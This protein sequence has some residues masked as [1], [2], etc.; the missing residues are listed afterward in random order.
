MV[1]R[2][3]RGFT[4][5]ELMVVLAIL[6]VLLAAAVPSLTAYLHLAQFRRNES[7]AKSIYLSAESTLTYYRGSGQW[8]SFARQL[9]AKGVQVGK[10]DTQLKPELHDR[11][12]A[13]RLDAK[14][15]GSGDGLSDDGA[16]TAQLLAN[17]TYDKS[18]LNGA[19]CLEIDLESG[20][21]YSA[22]YGAPCDGLRYDDEPDR[23][24]GWLNLSDRA[25]DSRKAARLGYY[26]ADDMTN[27]V[28][29]ELTKLKITSISLVNSETLSLS[30]SSN[31]KNHDHDVVYQ[32][33]FFRAGDNT[34]LLSTKLERPPGPAP[35]QITLKVDNQ[36]SKED[37]YTFPLSY[38]D[39]RFTL[40]LDAMMTAELAGNV[41][42]TP[43]APKTK[44]YFGTSITRF[45]GAF[46]TP[47]DIYA[48]VRVL[49]ASGSIDTEYTASNEAKS[50]TANT[51]FTDGSTAAECGIAAFRHL[52]NIRYQNGTGNQ[53]FRITARTLDWTS[54]SVTVYQSVTQQDGSG[55]VMGTRLTR[56]DD[57]AF[58]TVPE[59]GESKT[60]NGSGGGLLSR[61]LTA[62]TGSSAVVR[63]RLDETSVAPAAPGG[64]VYLGLFGQNSGTIT[65]LRLT[66]PEVTYT[67][68]PGQRSVHA[69]GAVCGYD[70]GSLQ[71][72]TVDGKAVV[73]VDL[74]QAERRSIG[75]L[76]GL[77]KP[78]DGR[79]L[80]GL[81]MAGTVNGTVVQ[82]GAAAASMAG[83][84]GIVGY[85]SL[86]P[87]RQLCQL[88]NSE[89]LA[90]VTGDFRVG[91]VAGC[92]LDNA[93]S[94]GAAPS[95]VSLKNC[96]N[97][98]LV[99]GANRD[100]DYVGGIAGYTG[101]AVLEGCTSCS[102]RSTGFAYTADQTNLLQGRYVGGIVG[103]G[104]NSYIRDCATQ[105]DG[106]IL[107]GSY[108]GGIAGGLAG[109]TQQSIQNQNV[110]V[111]AN[112]SYVIG[113][114]Y[115]G[116]IVG[117]NTGNSSIENCVN[118]GV[119]AGYGKYIG[120]ICGT[121]IRRGSDD[122]GVP[123]VKNCA[124]YVSDTDDSIYQKVLKWKAVGSCAGGLVGFNSGKIIFNDEGNNITT[125]S[126]SGIVVGKDYVGG[127]VGFNAEKGNI[128]V[129]YTL[130]GGRV[131]ASGDCVGGLIGLNA[132]EQVLTEALTIQPGSV[133]GRY[134]V[135]GAIGA[136]VVELNGD[137]TMARM[138][139]KNQ[140]GTV[141]GQ[142][143]T[144][145]LIGYHRTYAD[146]QLGG[147][148][149]E[150][151][152]D[153]NKNQLL[154]AIEPG[155]NI[156]KTVLKTTNSHVL[157][158][159]QEGGTA[160]INSMGLRG[161][162]Y[163]GGVVGGCEDG[164]KLVLKNCVNTGGFAMPTVFE[165]SGLA[166]GVD[167][168][169]LLGAEGYPDAA[170][171]LEAELKLNGT[172]L[173]ARIVGGVIGMTGRN[174]VVD[175]CS[176]T[177][178]MN[179]LSVLGG[180]VGLNEG[181][182]VNC[183]LSNNLGGATQ[184]Y[185][186]G[187][188][189]LNV[190][191]KDE[192]VTV[193]GYTY[194]GTSYIPGTV[195]HCATQANRTV[196]G[197]DVVGGIVGCNLDGGRMEQNTSNASVT[198]RTAV[199]GVVGENQGALTL[200]GSAGSEERRVTGQS[201]GSAVGGVIGRNTAGG[202]LAVSGS[203]DVAVTDGKLTVSG[204]DAVGGVI[205]LNRGTIKMPDDA[206]LTNQAKEVRAVN[207]SVGG[208]I[209]EQ[210]GAATLSRAK[211]LGDR[212][213]A[214]AGSAGGIVGVNRSGNTVK[215]CVNQGS[216]T[217]NQG[218]AGGIVSENYGTVT[219]CSVAALSGTITIGSRGADASGAICAVNHS[220][221]TVTGSAPGDGVQFTG[222][223]S[224]LGAVVGDNYGTVGNTTVEKLPEYSRVTPSS[225]T[226]GGAVGRNSTKNS[227]SGT[228]KD[229]T[230]R[231]RFEH[232][233]KYRYLGGVV[234]ENCEDAQVKG[235]SYT[236]TITEGRSAAG[237]CYGGV[238][239][240]NEGV[241]D[242]CTVSQLTIT[243]TGAYT[244]ASNSTAAQKEARSSHIGGIAGKNETTGKIVR[245]TLTAGADKPG[246]ITAKY[247]M[248]GGV[249]GYNKGSISLSGDGDTMKVMEYTKADGT[250]GPV[251]KISQ[252]LKKTGGLSADKTY[253]SY[254]NSVGDLEKAKYSNGT[255][256]IA[257]RTMRVKVIGNGNLGG[258][259][260]Y[261]APTGQLDHCVSGNWFLE[262][263]SG[264]LGVGT[265]GIIGM[266]ESE[267]DLTFLVNRAFVGRYL[268]SA[269]TNRFA[270]GIIGNQVNSTTENWTIRGC[271]NYGTVYCYNSH[272]SGGI[273]GQWTGNGGTI[274]DCYNY[275]NLQTTY[276]TNWV[277]ASGGIV[278]Q[279]YHAASNQSFNI[280]SCQNHG[281]IY[282]A[283]GTGGS[284]A[285]DSAGILGNIT[286]YQASD[287]GQRFT[288]HVVDCVNGPK[289]K[290][291]SASMASGI[292]GF[293][294][295]DGPNKG[296]ISNSTRNVVINLDRCRN[297]SAELR[298]GQW[299]YRAGIFGDRYDSRAAANTY[300]QN[301]YSV[302]VGYNGQ[303]MVSLRGTSSMRLDSSTVGNNYYF[304]AQWNLGQVGSDRKN[305]SGNLSQT[306]Q[307]AWKELVRAGVRQ[308]HFGQDAKGD[309]LAMLVGPDG[310]F[311]E[312]INDF[313]E[314]QTRMYRGATTENSYLDSQG[315]VH[316]YDNGTPVIAARTLFR[317]PEEYRKYM[318]AGNNS[319]GLTN[320]IKQDSAFD[321]YVRSGYHLLER[322]IS[323]G[324]AP[325]KPAKLAKPSGDVTKPGDAVTAVL[326]QDGSVQVS[327]ADNSRPLYYEGELWMNGTAAASGLRFIPNQ[328]DQGEWDGSGYRS[329]TTTSSFQLPESLRDKVNSGSGV[330]LRVRAVSLEENVAPSE[331]TEC[332]VVDTAFLP[333]PNVRVQLVRSGTSYVYQ[334]SLDNLS[335]YA[336]FPNWKVTLTM[337][338]QSIGTLTAAKPTV[339]FAG[340]GVQEL[341]A[342]ATADPI[343][344]KM[345]APA[346]LRVSAYTPVKFLPDSGLN[347]LGFEVTGDTLEDLVITAKLVPAAAAIN[348]PPIFRVELVGTVNGKETVFAYEDVLLAAGAEVDAHFRDM[349]EDIF[350]EATNLGIRAWYAAAGLGP[351]YT[352]APVQ[353]ADQAN[354]TLRNYDK[355][356]SYS[357]SYLN[358]TVLAANQSSPFTRQ[359]N[360]TNRELSQYTA[361]PKPVLGDITSEMKDGSLFY[362]FQWDQ[363][364]NA[365]ANARYRVKLIGE[366]AG[367]QVT[368][369]TDYDE[370]AGART[371]TV[372]A[373]DWSYTNVTLTVT[374]VGD[375]TAKQIGLSA[376]RKY[377]VQ[378]RL[379]R[380]GQPTVENV[381]TNELNY[382]VSWPAISNETG[383]TGYAIHLQY[384]GDDGN[385]VDT[386]LATVPADGSAAYSCVCDLEPYSGKEVLIYLVALADAN[387]KDS[388][389]GVS[390]TLV[391]PERIG[392]PTVTWSTNWTYD[393]ANPVSAGDFRGGGLSVTVIPQ[394]AASTPP[395]GSTYLL[396]AKV[397]DSADGSGTPVA[398]YPASGVLAMS[399]NSGG[400]YV[401]WLNDLSV[402]YAGKYIRFQARISS[403][404][405]QVSS[406]WVTS[407]VYRLPAMRLD[408]PGPITGSQ[409]V[410]T[411][412]SVR[413]N[414][415]L[416]AS[417]AVWT[418]Q[419]TTV[420]WTVTE[421]AEVYELTLNPG[422]AALR[423]GMEKDAVLVQRKKGDIW[424]DL[425]PDDN[426][427]Y[428]VLSGETVY[429]TYVDANG[430]G[431]TYSYVPETTLR[432]EE[433]ED[434]R[435]TF[436]LYL[437]NISAMTGGTDVQ[438]ITLPEQQKQVESLDI[439]AN[440]WD[441]LTDIPSD[442]YVASEK[443]ELKF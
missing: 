96:A 315:A 177:G 380:P 434:G 273:L 284:G 392:V 325:A 84:G 426:D 361:L 307:S 260:G 354:V 393:R 90:N 65:G 231:A 107:G 179:G 353:S 336:A 264:S 372:N 349:P 3:R 135:G 377:P 36:G 77:A 188:A 245:C 335:S 83:I 389:N 317:L 66:A 432:G 198:G 162:A 59:L 78:A 351:V 9:K 11:L 136:N 323:D 383:C 104:K 235:S 442:A 286:T 278:A 322:T 127:L 156:P 360:N 319:T 169:A 123:T 24:D 55:A 334:Y 408:T 394:D 131:A 163:V 100:S 103:Y 261:N 338:G 93:S 230:V 5:V 357:E 139:V 184:D 257:N 340:K 275:G 311:T 6:G 197:H 15:Y 157:T 407:D 81:S 186:G 171:A 178:A 32:L 25:Y 174:H 342:T 151:Y 243:A 205:G 271:V 268:S 153:A 266:N 79:V 189:G 85:L 337:G 419:R 249:T 234:G 116:G 21:V 159:T 111:T 115:V 421:P 344:G 191:A 384:T 49:P 207:G 328:K 251:E 140:L 125:R 277:G 12:Y 341:V 182:I 48:T 312:K 259:A 176:N 23:G 420:T 255:A 110:S 418:A 241:L 92:V 166:D 132:A 281:S 224:I 206:Y 105:A 119:V 395:G 314:H 272:Y 214:Q 129:S 57:P 7:Y 196:T 97:Q 86:P 122:S 316:A 134:Y 403:S 265:G 147:K 88:E 263:K 102:G 194:H 40:E 226:V 373:D 253:L 239:G 120:G 258:I 31:S 216:V 305:Y 292:V 208:V 385:P 254:T 244:A 150:Q 37:Q 44:T 95:T 215:D 348:T 121:N 287:G 355:D 301:C 109:S 227:K 108:V 161:Y 94:T 276:G 416:P 17:D 331:W 89:N 99:L 417:T 367:S 69:V 247:G 172:T 14:E 347:T 18:T 211:N 321:T 409:K 381:N 46:T 16:L 138:V 181:Y 280:L 291:Y 26:S 390:F 386:V 152:L 299:P 173:R 175:E 183:T 164:S 423:I 238:A 411:K 329:G 376:A 425:T 22:F 274:Q 180:V 114:D 370:S 240:R 333:T 339:T 309:W 282:R 283:N 302:L 250:T 236:G 154:P 52:Y 229:V 402:R 91:G 414:P 2:D 430:K 13:I 130:L 424:T 204:T 76:V 415:D 10:W 439:C 391:V 87:D 320:Q 30:W 167:V 343:G 326:G 101:G 358:S 303:E 8:D 401:L 306:Y 400:S 54:D 248:V 438:S 219:G 209:G 289:V 82:S 308:V 413:P 200:S 51:L 270:G 220:D 126:V 212:V 193:N 75:G 128:Q 368:I 141:S 371:L 285:N 352:Y 431:Q 53:T 369:P 388:A 73:A 242:G 61:A 429:G 293:L 113:N 80:T 149:M 170:Q 41:A 310:E 359:Y 165:N 269:Q 237:N 158:I 60:L 42:E 294:S 435:M 397:Y 332:A 304:K 412:V 106:Y 1:R 19:I 201:G 427:L 223:A 405:G 28:D 145:G 29:L 297:Y 374:R 327:I 433:D 168:A 39:G 406:P 222:T 117:E 27:V 378:S 296:T 288:I 34:P 350:T 217:N 146:G 74:S 279:L 155:T 118:T 63:V 324:S 58:P 20:Q 404:A 213:T 363:G 187:I 398:D 71:N 365:A 252:L 45:G 364:T 35:K 62:L 375:V 160:A 246:T 47:M 144:G 218:Y 50:N 356:G 379:E 366:A 330:T 232:F 43:F 362:T 399:A 33:K 410:D 199:G 422:A 345:P 56:V 190:G 70:T 203:G 256:V 38:D 290:I 133:Q 225:L 195:S 124:S 382:R 148:T 98:G 262:N 67:A 221:S 210:N 298:E 443:R 142:A 68:R 72:V 137:R 295:C 4:L 346:T 192:T 440:V 441:N 267:K 64:A 436:T 185:V 387:H 396:R 233:T 437:P 143:F 318:A 428:T 202:S 112:A 228:V 300:I 313:S